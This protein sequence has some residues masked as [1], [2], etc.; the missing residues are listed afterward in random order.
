MHFA[1]ASKAEPSITDK[2]QIYDQTLRQSQHA[3]TSRRR[4]PVGGSVLGMSALATGPS[5]SSIFGGMSTAQTAVLGDSQGSVLAADTGGISR[6]ELGEDMEPDGGVGSG[7]GESYVD[8]AKRP[9]AFDGE[10]DDE[11]GLRDGG[12]LSLLAQIYGRT[13]SAPAVL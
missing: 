6:A 10:E 4:I 2:A 7:L 12:V 13:E 9:G 8:G 5:S 11:D 1:G 3:V